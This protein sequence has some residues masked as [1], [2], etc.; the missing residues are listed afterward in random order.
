MTVPRVPTGKMSSGVGSL[1]LAFFCA[2]RKISLSARHRL[3][4]RGDGLLAADEEL[5]HHVR[6]DDDVAQREKGDR[7]PLRA[8]RP[9]AVVF[10]VEE[11]RAEQDSSAYAS[12]ASFW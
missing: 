10:L 1:V 6:E 7:A 3:F 2:A 9:L 4:E 11:H 12:S 5:R 8:G